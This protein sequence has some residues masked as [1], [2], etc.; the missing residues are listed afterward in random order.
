MVIPHTVHYISYTCEPV[1]P[2]SPLL[3]LCQ[4]RHRLR[5]LFTSKKNLNLSTFFICELQSA[6]ALRPQTTLLYSV[7]LAI[8]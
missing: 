2:V 3:L 6:F 1:E 7:H 4:K 5:L 8:F